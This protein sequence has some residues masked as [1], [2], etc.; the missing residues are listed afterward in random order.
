MGR[1]LGRGKESDLEAAFEQ[2]TDSLEAIFDDLPS[3]VKHVVSCMVFEVDVVQGRLDVGMVSVIGWGFSSVYYGS[4]N[5]TTDYWY[6]IWNSGDCYNFTL[7]GDATVQLE[8]KLMHPLVQNDPNWRIYTIPDEEFVT[9]EIYPAEFPFTPSPRG[10]RAFLHT[11]TGSW[12]G[13]QCLPPS[14]L[15]FYI[16]SNGIPYIINEYEPQGLDFT[17][18]NVERDVIFL[19]PV[20]FEEYHYFIITYAPKYRTTVPASGL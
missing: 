18:I 5:S 9:E 7:D 11:G 1:G 14:E 4:F 20:G 2:M 3:N 13:P 15:N 8:Y 10:F 17:E 12:D 16:S 19:D 6:S